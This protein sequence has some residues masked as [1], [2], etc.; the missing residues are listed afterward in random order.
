MCETFFVTWSIWLIYWEYEYTNENS[1]DGYIYV[2][3]YRTGVGVYS[4]FIIMNQFTFLNFCIIPCT[5]WEMR[6]YYFLN[7]LLA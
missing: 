3:I 6:I 5:F 2:Y 7:I 1:W 4:I